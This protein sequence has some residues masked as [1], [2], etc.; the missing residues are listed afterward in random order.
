MAGYGPGCGD[1]RDF[2]RVRLHR[3]PAD[4]LHPP[5]PRP[6]ANP[7]MQSSPSGDDRRHPAGGR[8]VPVRQR[9]DRDTTVGRPGPD[10]DRPRRAAARRVRVSRRSPLE[11][12]SSFELTYENSLHLGANNGRLRDAGPGRHPDRHRQRVGGPNV[13]DAAEP[14]SPIEDPSIHGSGRS[15]SIILP[16]QSRRLLEPSSSAVRRPELDLHRR[17]GRRLH[18]LPGRPRL[19]LPA[20]CPGGQPDQRR[21]DR[22]CPSTPISSCTGRRASRRRPPSSRRRPASCPASSSRIRGWASA[23]RPIR[24][25]PRPSATSSSTRATSRR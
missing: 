7:D 10:L 23:R 18:Q 16:G 4:L 9:P 19:V 17:D 25:R 20:E 12:S 5:A 2:D 6:G 15:D 24:S 11:R 14:N 13:L 22:T 3:E 1:D 21:P 8:P